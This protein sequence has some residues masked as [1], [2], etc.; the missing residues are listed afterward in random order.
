MILQQQSLTTVLL[1]SL[2]MMTV[3][4]KTIEIDKENAS[5]NTLLSENA[6]NYIQCAGKSQYR[7]LNQNEIGLY[8]LSFES[9]DRRPLTSIKQD[10]MKPLE[11]RF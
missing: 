4:F 2:V 6:I 1:T 9:K 11:Y 10:L 3:D 7:P 8:D 5:S